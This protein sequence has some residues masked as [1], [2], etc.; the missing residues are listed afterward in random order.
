MKKIFSLL[1]P[2]L[3]LISCSQSGDRTPLGWCIWEIQKHEG[4]ENCYYT[5]QD[6]YPLDYKSES[7][8][9]AN[10]YIITTY[11]EELRTEWFCF[12]EYAKTIKKYLSPKDVVS[13]DCDIVWE[14]NYEETGTIL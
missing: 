7:D 3:F 13:I 5:V 4:Y 2:L 8:F 12:I 11:T 14:I 10:A 9:N 6:V 1:I